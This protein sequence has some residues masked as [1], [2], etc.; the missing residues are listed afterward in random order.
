MSLP[1]VVLADDH[2][3][4]LAQVKTILSTEFDI[5]DAVADGEAA[6]EAVRRLA[7]DAVILD[8]S[9]PR[10]S[11]FEAAARLTASDDA[12]AIIFLTMH[13]GAEFL[14]AAQRAGVTGYVLK[15]QIATQLRP[16]VRDA[17]A[18]RRLA[19]ESLPRAGVPATEARRVASTHPI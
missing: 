10:L 19:R 8:I 15:R 18:A 14:E 2:P 16:A 13:E 1:R 12:P 17:I 3:A 7:P 5:V 11:G 4:V 6:V 9:M